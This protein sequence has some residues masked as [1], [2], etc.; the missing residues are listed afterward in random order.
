MS[1]S[2]A[3]EKKPLTSRRLLAIILTFSFLISVFPSM[4][5]LQSQRVSAAAPENHTVLTGSTLTIVHRV[6][7]QLLKKKVEYLYTSDGTP[8]YCIKAASNAPTGG[9][10][11]ASVLTDSNAKALLRKIQ[12]IIDYVNPGLNSTFENY[13]IIRTFHK[14]RRG[15]T[16]RAGGNEGENSDGQN[17]PE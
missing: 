3:K 10:L 13:A 11:A 15:K 7:G 9:S 6:D 4:K 16:G 2:K 17:S 5:F 14:D 12:Y 1:S 8:V